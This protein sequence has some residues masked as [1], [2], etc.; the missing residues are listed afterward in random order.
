[1]KGSEVNKMSDEE[2]KVE[3]ARLRND[4]YDL[5]TQS[6]TEKVEDTS[7]QSKARKDIA[8]LL[9]LQRARAMAK[10]TNPKPRMRAARRHRLAA[11]GHKAKTKAAAKKVVKKTSAPR[12]RPAKQGAAKPSTA[13]RH[14]A[15]QLKAKGQKKAAGRKS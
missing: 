14:S 5:R 3:L 4:L 9:T 15:R 10:E 13:S 7:R 6:I 8:R 2:L 1:M 11:T 12:V